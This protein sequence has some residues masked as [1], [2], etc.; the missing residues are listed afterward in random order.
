[1]VCFGCKIPVVSLVVG[2]SL[3]VHVEYLLSE[4][5]YSIQVLS[6]RF[7]VLGY[8]SIYFVFNNAA[9][10]LGHITQNGSIIGGE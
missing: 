9:S 1:M 7:P 4:F 3:C 10:S 5:L 2:V 8:S 6:S